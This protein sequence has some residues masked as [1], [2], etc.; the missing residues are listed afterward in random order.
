MGPD[1][2]HEEGVGRIPPQGG[3]QDD[4]EAT[5]ERTER[6]V[7]LTPAGGFDDGGGIA[8]DGDLQLLQPEHSRTVY[9]Y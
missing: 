6:S 2:S 1:A 7:V 4:G 3:P 8:R 5:V 9:C